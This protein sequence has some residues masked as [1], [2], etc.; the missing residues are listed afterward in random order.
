MPVSRRHALQILAAAGITGPAALRLAAQAR[1]QLTLDNLKTATVLLN[2]EFDD[3]RLQ[4][5]RTALQRNLDQFQ[6]VRDLVID[7]SI[8]PAPIVDAMRH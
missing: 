6:G 8:E 2:R 4:V 3:E 5:I 7:D 1:H